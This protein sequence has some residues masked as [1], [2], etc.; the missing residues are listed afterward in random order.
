MSVLVWRT[1]S[2]SRN[3]G[4]MWSFIL[5]RLHELAQYGVTN[6]LYT[7][8]WAPR[9]EVLVVI[10][11]EL[12]VKNRVSAGL[13]QELLVPHVVYECFRWKFPMCIVDLFR[14]QQF[15]IFLEPCLKKHIRPIFT[16]PSRY[17]L[18]T[19]ST[20]LTALFELHI[21]DAYIGDVLLIVREVQHCCQRHWI[22]HVVYAGLIQNSQTA[23]EAFWREL[24][25]VDHQTLLEAP[26]SMC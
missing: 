3:A 8:S 10:W 13:R 12:L 14:N 16:S 22:F 5:S 25:H 2:S 18:H 9:F 15:Y 24:N 23:L 21:L 19:F 11:S 7:K 26:L 1:S 6:A 17:E 4:I 20:R